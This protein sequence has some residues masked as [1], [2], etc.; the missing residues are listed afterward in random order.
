MTRSILSEITGGPVEVQFVVAK[1]VPSPQDREM[2]PTQTPTGKKPYRLPK[3]RPVKLKQDKYSSIINS[4][5]A[6]VISPIVMNSAAPTATRPNAHRSA[7][8]TDPST[9]RY[10]SYTETPEQSKRRQEKSVA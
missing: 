8:S 3:N 2:R 9:E 7:D 1:E 4:L 10:Q 5:E 6:T